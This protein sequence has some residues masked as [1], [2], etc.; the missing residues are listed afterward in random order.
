MFH[1]QRTHTHHT[2]TQRTHTHTPH[3]HTQP[4]FYQVQ[5]HPGLITDGGNYELSKSKW[6]AMEP[7]DIATL[8]LQLCLDRHVAAQDESSYTTGEN[9]FTHVMSLC[10][11]RFSH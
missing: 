4:L 7:D 6:G 3:T 10:G 2:H 9:I 5:L 8:S 11:S 1:T